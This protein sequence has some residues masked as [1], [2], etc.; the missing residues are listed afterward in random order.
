VSREIC[1]AYCSKLCRVRMVERERE[2]ER[3]REFGT[4]K[5]DNIIFLEWARVASEQTTAL[6]FTRTCVY[7]N[8]SVLRDIGQNRNGKNREEKREK[9]IFSAFRYHA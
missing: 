9:E 5:S 3:E 4:H 7:D 2:R 1:I 8:C 6:P